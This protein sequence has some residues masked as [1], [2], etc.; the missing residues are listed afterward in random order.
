[1]TANRGVFF[2]YMDTKT[3]TQLNLLYNSDY[4][5]QIDQQNME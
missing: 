4:N 3:A 2:I 5:I 1:M